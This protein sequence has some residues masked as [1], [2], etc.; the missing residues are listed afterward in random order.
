MTRVRKYRY[1][2]QGQEQDNE[3]AGEGNSYT[4][5]FWQYDSR[6]GRR[7]NIDPV[8]KEHESPYAAFA[9]N[10]I[11]F[12]DPLG[13]DSTVYLYSQEIDGAAVYDMEM[14]TKMATEAQNV[15]DKNG[16]GFITFKATTKTDLE[17]NENLNPYTDLIFA[18]TDD[19]WKGTIFPGMTQTEVTG[20]NFGQAEWQGE[21]FSHGEIYPNEL[22]QVD[23][24]FFTNAG[25]TIAHEA[26]THG[27][28]HIV[29]ALFDSSNGGGHF[30]KGLENANITPNYTLSYGQLRTS[31]TVSSRT[32][33]TISSLFSFGA[34]G[35]ATSHKPSLTTYNYGEGNN[36]DD[37]WNDPDGLF[38]YALMFHFSSMLTTK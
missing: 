19:I 28:P 6:L 1:G 11:W 20:T 26:F 17:Q 30:G 36:Y 34:G 22:N 31:E 16:L 29:N 12:V 25:A 4:A 37:P 2:F 14:L 3:V 35:F 13:A 8:V 7:W 33:K 32:K 18:V 27:Y 38:T 9:N 24:S 10:P 5:E 21:I 15:A 23:G